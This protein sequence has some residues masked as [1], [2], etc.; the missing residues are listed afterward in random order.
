MRGPTGV[1]FTRSPEALSRYIGAD[2]LVTIPGD[3]QVHELSGGA[4]AIWEELRTPRDVVD[5]IDRLTSAHAAEPSLIATQVEECIDTLLRLR[6]VEEVQE[7]D[8]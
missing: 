8:G 6:V 2:V 5:L 3:E 7:F 4:S 1:R